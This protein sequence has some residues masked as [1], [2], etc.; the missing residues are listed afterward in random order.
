[1]IVQMP[2]RPVQSLH[3]LAGVEVA[4][5]TREIARARRALRDGQGRALIASLRLIADA[6]DIAAQDLESHGGGA[7]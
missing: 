1:M 7:A 4:V 2:S 5:I 6:A 3:D